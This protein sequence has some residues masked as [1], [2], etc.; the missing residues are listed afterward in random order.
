[1]LAVL[2]LDD[3]LAERRKQ[4]KANQ[5]TMLDALKQEFDVDGDNTKKNYRDEAQLRCLSEICIMKFI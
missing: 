2:Q 5:K 4:L 3:V 1:M